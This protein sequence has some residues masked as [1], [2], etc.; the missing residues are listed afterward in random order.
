MTKSNSLVLITR[1]S[2]PVLNSTALTFA[3]CLEA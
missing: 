2:I 1:A 3:A